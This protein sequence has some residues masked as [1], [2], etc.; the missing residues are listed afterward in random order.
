MSQKSIHCPHCRGVIH[1]TESQTGETP[2]CPHCGL[3]VSLSKSRSEAAV[4]KPKAAPHHIQPFT[5]ETWW[6]VGSKIVGFLIVFIFPVGT[7]LGPMLYYFG[8]QSER[9]FRCTN[10]LNALPER[11][12]SR[13]PHCKCS[14]YAAGNYSWYYHRFD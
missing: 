6:S 4:A 11:S 7:I 2:P 12:I 10:C 13:C 1:F 5:S 8:A 14:L 9:K 3:N